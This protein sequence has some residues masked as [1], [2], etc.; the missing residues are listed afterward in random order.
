MQDAM[1][2]AVP[3]VDQGGQAIYPVSAPPPLAPPPGPVSDAAVHPGASGAAPVDGSGSDWQGLLNDPGAMFKEGG[4]I[5]YDRLASELAP[6]GASVLIRVVGVLLL[7]LLAWLVARWAKAVIVKALSKAHL[8][9]TIVQF[10]GTVT[11]T[12]VMVLAVILALG[13]FGVETTTFAAMLGAAGLAVGLAFQ[14]AL[15]NLAAGVMLLLFRPFRVGEFVEIGDESGT[16]EEVGLYFTR[17][18][19]LDKRY[20]LLPNDDVIGGK[21]ENCSRRAVLRVDVPIGVSYHADPKST[22]AALEKAI[23]GVEGRVEEGMDVPVLVGFGDSSVDWE[24]RVHCRWQDRVVVRERVLVAIW[25]ALVEAGIE[26]PFPQR[27]IHI[28]APVRVRMERPEG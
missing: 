1:T 12:A 20:V 11:S 19:T 28:N 5:D 7:L 15:S 14:G 22:R 24:A 10:A 17:I 16:V 13:L 4:G 25:D 23:A 6:L 8:D 21:I 9:K 3:A 27:D 2:Q 26:I 18:V